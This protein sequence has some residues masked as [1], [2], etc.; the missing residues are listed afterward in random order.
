MDKK[1][2]L[3]IVGVLCVFLSL[4]G[5]FVLPEIG[6]GYTILIG[7]GSACLVMASD[8]GKKR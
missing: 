1:I 4:I 3:N 6:F 5:M 8:I 2:I 7:V